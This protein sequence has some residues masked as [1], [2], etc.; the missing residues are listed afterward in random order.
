M[1]ATACC[2]KILTSLQS[3]FAADAHL[4]EVQFLKDE[5]S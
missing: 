4:A 5:L 3:V 2:P 1:S